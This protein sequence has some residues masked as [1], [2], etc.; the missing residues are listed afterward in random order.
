MNRWLLLF[1]RLVLPFGIEW[2]FKSILMMPET[3]YS[4]GGASS[5]HKRL[6]G[7]LRLIMAIF[8]RFPGAF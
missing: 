4:A 8:I 3:G 5:I 2:L 1:I 7:F 6:D